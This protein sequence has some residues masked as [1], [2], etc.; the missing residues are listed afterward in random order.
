MI[1]SFLSVGD[2]EN[3]S[4]FSCSFSLRRREENKVFIPLESKP[5][6][7]RQAQ[8]RLVGAI[9]FLLLT[10]KRK[11]SPEAY[12]EGKKIVPLNIGELLTALGLCYW[13]CDDGSF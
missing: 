8:P 7:L 4:L 12:S 1:F 3:K 9:S 13:I 6:L 2:R 11:N 5:W 10:I